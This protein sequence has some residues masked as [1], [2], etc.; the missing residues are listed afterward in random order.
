M[1]DVSDPFVLNVA[2]V[3]AA[4]AGLFLVGVFFFVETGLRAST[5]DESCSSRTSAPGRGSC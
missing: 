1:R 2:E 3:T 5:A 4:L